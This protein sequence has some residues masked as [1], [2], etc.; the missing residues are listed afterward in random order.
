MAPAALIGLLCL[1]L[2]WLYFSR[3]TP[4]PPAGTPAPR[5]VASAT[6][7]HETSNAA[8]YD[9][10]QPGMALGEVNTLLGGPGEEIAWRR[11]HGRTLQTLVW[12]DQTGS[13]LYATFEDDRLILK[14]RLGVPSFAEDGPAASP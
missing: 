8:I 4:L 11:L 5:V 13:T 1:A 2:A 9:R 10:L 3:P 12:T 7:P 14:S 6:P